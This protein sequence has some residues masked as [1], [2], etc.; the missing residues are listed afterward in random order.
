MDFPATLQA[1][2]TEPFW[3]VEVAGDVLLYT[4]PETMDAPRR[5]QATRSSDAE[6]LH[7]VGGNGDAGLRLDVR[8]E[9]C[10]DGM[11]DREYPFS[12]SLLLDGKT[13]RG[14]AFDPASP[15]PP[16]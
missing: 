5:L 1:I 9:A 4:T 12:V 8:R 2:G 10:S 3:S 13:A 15:P 6:G 11:S 14:C 16:Q 7:L